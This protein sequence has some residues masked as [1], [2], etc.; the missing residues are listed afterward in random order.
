MV[1]IQTS[2]SFISFI[3]FVHVSN[4][5]GQH[6]YYLCWF[7]LCCGDVSAILCMVHV[8]MYV[9][10]CLFVCKLVQNKHEFIIYKPL[11]CVHNSTYAPYNV[12][13]MRRHFIMFNQ[14]YLI[15]LNILINNKYSIFIFIF[16]FVWCLDILYP[17]F[18]GFYPGRQ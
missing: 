14:L 18:I 17:Q 8:C 5:M 15:K 9:H 4:R 10:F 13:D 3:S 7:L 11:N 6:Y 16:I 1:V 2:N 12:R